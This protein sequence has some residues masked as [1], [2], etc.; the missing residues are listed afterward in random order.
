MSGSPYYRGL[1]IQ[2]FRNTGVQEY[3]MSGNGIIIM[4]SSHKSGND[5]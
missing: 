4:P 5:E 2:E 3:Q 1:G